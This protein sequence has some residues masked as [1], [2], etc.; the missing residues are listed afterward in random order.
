MPLGISCEYQ[1][2][3]HALF[4][5]DLPYVA[6]HRKKAIN[7]AQSSGRAESEAGPVVQIVQ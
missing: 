4:A 7:A 2:G 6:F 3:D 1:F 5:S